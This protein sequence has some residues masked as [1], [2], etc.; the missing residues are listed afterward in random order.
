MA[1][2]ASEIKKFIQAA[3]PDATLTIEDL[4]GDGDHYAVHVISPAFASK[5]RIQQHQMVYE[6]LGGRVGEQLHALSIKTSVPPV[7]PSLTIVES[8]S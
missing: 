8:E 7:T 5:S 2:T 3:I 4:A 1:I 6:A